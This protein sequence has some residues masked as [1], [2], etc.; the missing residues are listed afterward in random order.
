MEDLEPTTDTHGVID[1]IRVETGL[2]RFPIHSLTGGGVEINLQNLGTATKWEVSHN[3]KYG[4]AGW[5]AYKIDTLIIN[6]RIEQQNRPI[7]K[8]IRL[9]SLREIA[10]EIST[11]GKRG[12]NPDLVK[13]ALMQNASTFINAKISYKTKEGSLREIEFGDSRYSVIFTGEK[14]PDGKKAD[15]VY[16]ILHDIYRDILNSAQTRPLDYAYMK[17]LPPLAQ[18]FYEIVSYIIYA[19]LYHKNVNCKMRY[20]EFCKLSTA[21]RYDTF[22]QVKKQMYKIHRPHI[23]SGYL[24]AGITYQ[25]ST[26]E[27][28][29]SDWWMYYTP[30]PNAGKQYNEFLAT[31]RKRATTSAYH[32]D[33]E[34]LPFLDDIPMIPEKGEAK[35]RTASKTV[36]IAPQESLEGGGGVD[37]SSVTLALRDRL[38]EI[39]MG[40]GEAL[41]QATVNPEECERQLE[42][43]PFAEVKTTPGAYLA[44]AIKGGFSPSKSYLEAKGKEEEKE[45][46]RRAEEIRQ[47]REQ[48][49]KARQEAEQTLLD[50]EIAALELE[51][52][53]QFVAFS[54]FVQGHRETEAKRNAKFSESIQRRMRENFERP[55]KR[56]ELYHQWKRGLGLAANPPAEAS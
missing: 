26:D 31:P 47:A 46:K 3:S 51:H 21:T 13:K 52:P 14:F 42:Y 9:G 27:A 17:V 53:E 11:E 7:P 56:H 4:Q 20:S 38:V 12:A 43:L 32:S 24:E 18:R 35:P 28:G 39:G 30:G 48:T 41:T 33:Q 23:L 25:A 54:Q 45:K 29:K 44:S 6:R 16:I 10:S 34:I 37:P 36:K 5:L 50:S 8:I 15:A 1:P 22:D 19:C 49:E 2:S 55:E 40:R